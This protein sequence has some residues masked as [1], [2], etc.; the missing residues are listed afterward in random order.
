MEGLLIGDKQKI[1]DTDPT[2][3]QYLAGRLKKEELIKYLEENRH[4]LI[5]QGLTQ[6]DINTLIKADDEA[7]FA[8]KA[9]QARFVRFMRRLGLHLATPLDKI[10]WIKDHSAEQFLDVLSVANGLLRGQGGFQRFERPRGKT[11]VTFGTSAE[12]T[13][14]EPPADSWK[15]F[16]QFYDQMRQNITVD[17]LSIWAAKLYVAIIFAHI[18]TDGNGRLARSAYYVLRTQGVL[19]ESRPSERGPIITGLCNQINANV[20]TRLANREGIQATTETIG[21]YV[22][23]EIETPLS[24]YTLS[25]KFIAARRVLKRRGLYTTEQKQLW[26]GNWTPE[27]MQEFKN[28]Y[29]NVLVEWFWE[30]FATVEKYSRHIIE[31]LD[32]ALLIS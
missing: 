3:K 5:A 30:A 1:Y 25:L 7:T 28:E 9:G 17:N 8:R 6:D 29:E 23:N 21:E 27:V 18:F 12:A 13:E 14:I 4:Q 26:G 31:Q 15:F 16:I 32:A 11:I 2:I 20:I 19:D 10:V 24:G 22:A